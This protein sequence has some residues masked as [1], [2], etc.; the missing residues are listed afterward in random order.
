[1]IAKALNSKLVSA[2]AS[3]KGWKRKKSIE[4]LGYGRGFILVKET[5]SNQQETS[6]LIEFQKDTLV[7]SDN[8]SQR[9][10]FL[11]QAYTGS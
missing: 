3:A 8:L 5:L 1:M 4:V 10:S 6:I 11:F 7:R 9:P 2:I